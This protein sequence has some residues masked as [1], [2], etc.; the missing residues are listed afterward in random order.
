LIRAAQ[1]TIARS[2]SSMEKWW[3]FGDFTG[4]MARPCEL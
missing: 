3:V 2:S 4:L 1:E